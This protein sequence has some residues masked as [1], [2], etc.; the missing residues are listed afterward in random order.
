MRQLIIKYAILVIV[1]TLIARLISTPI[2]ILFPT[3]LTKIN[4]D[5]STTTFPLGFIERA[6]EYILNISIVILM[7]KDFDKQNLK[8]IPILIVTFFFNFIGVIFFL[9]ASL[10]NKLTLKRQMT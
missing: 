10:Q 7:K 2:M 5:G 6:L 3:L 8:S 1:I 9:L 4:P